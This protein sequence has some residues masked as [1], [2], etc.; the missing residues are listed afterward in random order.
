[1]VTAA[2]ALI[3]RS[4]A[5]AGLGRLGVEFVAFSRSGQQITRRLETIRFRA[6]DL[7]VLRGPGYY[8][9]LG[10]PLS[11]MVLAIGVP[12]VMLVWPIA[13]P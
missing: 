9:K 8:W 1:V 3:D 11:I 7:V 2:S 10:L 6:G 5:H 13:R 12:L 4:A